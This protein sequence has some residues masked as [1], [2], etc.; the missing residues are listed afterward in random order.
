MSLIQ[1]DAFELPEHRRLGGFDHAA[2][3]F[4]T[5]R[6]YVAH[7]VNDSLD[8]I[9]CSAARFL[10]SIPG[11]TGVAGAL[12]SQDRVLVFTSNR[13]EDT[14]S[15]FA[16]G[17]EHHIEKIPVGNH[18]NGLSFDP[19]R[20]LLLAANV[21]DPAIPDSATL[22]IV[23]IHKR[24][25]IH[26]IPVPGRTRW[27]I[28][29]PR[30]DEFLTNISEPA[31]IVVVDADKPDHIVRS[32]TIPA[33]GPHG[34]D[35]DA[36]IGRLFCACDEGKLITLEA[37]NGKILNITELSGKPDVIFFNRQLKHLYIA[38]GDSGVI[39]VVDTDRFTRLETVPTEKG[40]HTLACDD[41]LNKIY[42]LAPQSHSAMVFIDE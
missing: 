37:S 13:G 26:S 5:N 36:D 19:Q 11:L 3:H 29:D 32:M 25:M 1:V 39:D 38:V 14:I 40:A 41:R 20:G 9:D 15:I 28:F 31:Q 6:L 16:P 12:V 30:N 24:E 21:G 17:D 42:A 4:R 10:A 27:S 7:T 2:I 35:L 22:S 33:A 8:I 34:L 23:D 18:P